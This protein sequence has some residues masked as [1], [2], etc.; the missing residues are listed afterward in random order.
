MSSDEDE[1]EGPEEVKCQQV[2]SGNTS[3][4]SDSDSSIEKKIKRE[5]KKLE[6]EPNFKC[7]FSL[8]GK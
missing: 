1:D 3:Y 6:V 5:M 7:N 8:C 4:F 2:D